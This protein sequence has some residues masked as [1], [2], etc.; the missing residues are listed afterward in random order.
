MFFLEKY[1]PLFTLVGNDQ[2]EAYDEYIEYQTLPNES[3]IETKMFR[4]KL[5]SLRVKMEMVLKYITSGFTF[6]VGT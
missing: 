1:K 6:S 2:N 5:K 3:F 4:R